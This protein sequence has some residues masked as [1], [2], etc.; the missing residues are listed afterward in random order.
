[1]PSATLADRRLSI[2]ARVAT[3]NAAP[4]RSCILPID[5]P[6]R[7]GMRQ[8][9][10]QCA[11]PG[12]VPAGRPAPRRSATTTASSEAGSA[13]CTRGAISMTP[14]ASATMASAPTSTWLNPS[15]S[16]RAA[17][18]AVL[19]PAGFA[20]PSAFGTC[21]RKMI[22]AMPTVNP[23]I[24]GH[25]M[26]ARSRPTRASDATTTSTPAIRPTSKT[27]CAP[28]RETIGTRTTAI[29]PV[30][31]DTCTFEPP[32]TA[33]TTPAT[34]AV[35]RPAVGAQAARD[36]ERERE[37]QRDHTDG[38]AG[39]EVAAPR[40]SQP[41]VVGAPRQQ[42]P[43]RPA[44]GHA[45]LQD[46]GPA[47]AGPV[48]IGGRVLRR[49]VRHGSAVPEIGEQ[50]LGLGQRVD[51]ELASPPRGAR[52]AGD[53][54]SSRRPPDPPCGSRR[55]GP[56]AGPRVAGTGATTR[57]RRAAAS[58]RPSALRRSAARAPGCGPGA[59]AP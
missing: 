27:A 26:Y 3:A 40:A 5:T 28:Y 1:M 41:G 53:R 16:A 8:R 50:I 57:A 24:T 51:E 15:T 2:A 59:P 10:R 20:T 6:G 22:T 36:P 45:G 32:N 25:G 43:D 31:P 35:I 42:P 49:P 21:W 34:I 46:P 13:R 11:D 52:P 39:D 37:R 23:S 17:T 4:R 19:S 56:G 54:G 47:A 29:A 55:A 48:V 33:A 7:D 30:G 9:I 38:D 12:D 18:T 58:R 14:T 44:A